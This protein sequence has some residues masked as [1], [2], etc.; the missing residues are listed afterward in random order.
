VWRQIRGGD[1]EG[2]LQEKRGGGQGAQKYRC[3]LSPV[4]LPSVSVRPPLL[5]VPWTLPSPAAPFSASCPCFGVFCWA[6]FEA[7]LGLAGPFGA[8][9]EDGPA[10]SSRVAS[11][12]SS[13]PF[14]SCSTCQKTLNF[15]GRCNAGAELG[16]LYSLMNRL[17][18]LPN[19]LI[20]FSLKQTC[21]QH[22]QTCS[23]TSY[24]ATSCLSP[25]TAGGSWFAFFVMAGFFCKAF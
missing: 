3:D 9:P 18:P 15:Q 20:C 22:L 2:G 23:C 19:L 5:P 16:F 11:P 24:L 1:R 17:E 25:N 10:T 12:P 13:L 8:A 21:V 14:S 4:A 6:S 7:G